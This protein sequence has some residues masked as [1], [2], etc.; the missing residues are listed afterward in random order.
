[1]CVCWFGLSVFVWDGL[2]FGSS[3]W[4]SGS[5]SGVGCDWGIEKDIGRETVV[6]K[7]GGMV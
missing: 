5:K 6:R 1:M 7:M 2:V 4:L 3:G